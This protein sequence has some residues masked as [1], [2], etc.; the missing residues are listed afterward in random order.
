MNS[1]SLGQPFEFVL[2]DSPQMAAVAVN[3]TAFAG[4]FTESPAGESI[5]SFPNTGNDASLLVPCPLASTAAYASIATFSRQAPAVQQHALWQAAGAA[6]EHAV[7]QQTVWLSTS[8]LGV[9]WLH[10]RLDQR[11]KYY[12]YAPYRQVAS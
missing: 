1:A 10:L 2:V 11:P 12:N 4:Y 5:V 7:Q 3:P 8:G 9:A 6:L